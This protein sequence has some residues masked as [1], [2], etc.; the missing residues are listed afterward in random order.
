MNWKAIGAALLTVA[1]IAGGLSG[2]VP[3]KYAWIPTLVGSLGQAFTNP[4]QE[5]DEAK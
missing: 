2:A 3:P 1:G 4:V 5:P